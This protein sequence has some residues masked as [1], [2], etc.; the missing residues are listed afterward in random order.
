MNGARLS[1][2]GSLNSQ[3]NGCDDPLEMSRLFYFAGSGGDG[4]A[5]VERGDRRMK[6]SKFWAVFL[7]MV[8]I[9]SC[10][11][12][13]LPAATPAPAAANTGDRDYIYDVLNDTLA[14]VRE[15][16]PYPAVGSIGGEWA[17]LALA[18][19]GVVDP[20][21]YDLYLA[22]LKKY[23]VTNDGKGQVT[24][25]DT[26]QVRLHS[27]TRTDEER[28]ILALSAL[29][30]DAADWEGYDLIS[31]LTDKQTTGVNA[32]E[33]QAVWQGMNGAVFALIALDACGY[34]A[35]DASEVR[36]YYINY[37]L[38]NAAGGGWGVSPHSAATV[39]MT[40]MGIQALAPYY[41]KD[42]D[43][44]NSAV[45][46]A[47]GLL[48]AKQG[49]NGDLGDSEGTVQTIVALSALGL[50]A[51]TDPRFVKNG[52]SLINGLLRYQVD[53]GGFRHVI[54]GGAD[55][56]A[57]EQAA[58]ALAAYVRHLDGHN[59]LYD[60]RDADNIFHDGP[61]KAV[62]RLSIAEAKALSSTK[63]TQ[64]SWAALLAALTGA[65]VAESNSAAAQAA[66]DAAEAALR[67]ALSGLVV[68]TG[69][70]GGGGGGA[71]YGDMK[72][73][74]AFTGDTLHGEG[75]KHSVQTWI[76]SQKVDMPA[77]S[78]VK[79]LTDTMLEKYGI[80]FSSRDGGRYIEWVVIPNTSTQLGEFDN[81]PNS[82]WMYRL[83]GII[84]GYGYAEETLSDG[85][86][87]VW[88]YTDDY[89]K[90]TGY[91]GTWRPGDPAV[92]GGGAAGSGLGGAGGGPSLVSEA[93]R[94]SGADRVQT[95]VAI[96]RRGWTSAESVFIVP[97]AG[98]NL[99]DAL[100]VA[101]LAGQENAPI[102]LSLGDALAPAVETEI[103]R[104]GA[105][106]IYT[107]GAVS[108]EVRRQL[109]ERFPA[110][111]MIGLHGQDRYETAALVD[112]KVADPQGVFV[113]GYNALADAVSAASYAA[114]HG[115]L[116]QIA[117]PDGSFTLPAA[118]DKL[119]GYIL[120]GPALVRDHP[121]YTRVYGADRY[122]TNEALRA[123]LDFDY[124]NIYVADG[125]TLVDALTG[126]ALAAQTGAAIV[127]APGN[128]LSATAVGRILTAQAASPEEAEAVQ[129]DLAAGS[130]L[131][132]GAAGWDK[133][134]AATKVYAF[135]GQ[136]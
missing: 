83:N 74:F 118:A 114:A 1:L 120:G 135:G 76:S 53:E 100:A 116:L 59:S 109:G 50:N 10:L 133:I 33:Y 84:V 46:K 81:G 130:K 87:V 91:D 42:R 44:I 121:G 64:T 111:E 7:A 5:N 16:T 25:S 90:E 95:S 67:A 119:P 17:V 125:A 96:A 39:D 131:G 32:G 40:A 115:W 97:G 105:K 134:T 37:I 48:S 56:M 89:T 23:I 12:A 123:A 28:V 88:F 128:D 98:A 104:L 57:S 122:A 52:Q 62:L 63:Y 58:Y 102:L 101:P 126:S 124:T 72:V 30:E 29:G 106:K 61:N 113:V 34:S 27:K 19:A 103:A 9:L 26:G 85:D 51:A 68:T 54:S 8:F 22:A 75:G 99:I 18:R 78:T 70:G 45:D 43:D 24:V 73:T 41:D 108:A 21:W 92:G 55:R 86:S 6:K 3:E 47:L 132:G 79:D 20:D 13:G 38:K 35:E 2:T 129:A 136:K 15:R 36:D 82:G 71:V 93:N 80:T 112:A 110:A 77:G 66:I 60:M 127:L 107:V 4:A 14:Y 11:P 65:E 31:A 94:I 117:G 49:P 69:S